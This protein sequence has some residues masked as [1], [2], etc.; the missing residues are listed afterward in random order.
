MALSDSRKHNWNPREV[1]GLDPLAANFACVGAAITKGGSRCR[2]RLDGMTCA[3]ADDLLNEMATTYP[4][5]EP[6]THQLRRLASLLLCKEYHQYQADRMVREWVEKI[7]QSR[8]VQPE[9]LEPEKSD[10]EMQTA[11]S[12]PSS[13]S[14]EAFDTSPISRCCIE[15]VSI[16]RNRIISI[17]ANDERLKP[18]Y[19]SALNNPSIGAIQFE[20]NFRRFLEQYA[21]DLCNEARGPHQKNVAHVFRIHAGDIAIGISSQIDG[22]DIKCSERIKRCMLEKANSVKLVLFSLYIWSKGTPTS[23]S[24]DNRGPFI[25]IFVILTF[26]NFIIMTLSIHWMLSIILIA[27]VIGIT[28]CGATAYFVVKHYC[29]F[30]PQ[31]TADDFSNFASSRTQIKQF[32]IQSNAF[33]TFR[34]QL[35]QFVHLDHDAFS[36]TSAFAGS[37]AID[38]KRVVKFTPWTKATHPGYIDRIKGTLEKRARSPVIWWPLQPTRTRCPNGYTR[39]SW[40]CVS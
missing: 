36:N 11:L 6:V 14:P 23:D 1:L 28:I 20:S 7:R 4:I 32:M 30:Y 37:Y 3:T 18:L 8:I 24:R 5:E 13:A 39:I 29:N 17:L 21:E 26:F 10:D 9:T 12:C 16:F 34:Q 31:Y 27:S 22:E 15:E 19:S 38:N 40:A 2:W 33:N 25:L 35:D